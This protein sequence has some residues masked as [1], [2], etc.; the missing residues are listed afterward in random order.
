MAT[1]N[2]SQLTIPTPQPYDKKDEQC[3]Q[4]NFFYVLNQ[5]LVLMKVAGF[6]VND[7]NLPNIKTAIQGIGLTVNPPDLSAM[8][9]QITTVN[10]KLDGLTEKLTALV[11]VFE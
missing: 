7:T 10:L 4:E 9:Q 6:Q 1:I 3:Q 5:L 8:T 2:L 11:E